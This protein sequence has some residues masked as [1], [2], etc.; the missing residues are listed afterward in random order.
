MT[1]AAATKMT[2]MGSTTTRVFNPATRLVAGRLPGFGI[3]THR[4]RRTGKLYHTPLLA[5][6]SGDDYVIGLWYGS[7]VHW[8]KNVIAAGTCQLEVRRRTVQVVDPVVFR[9]PNRSS[10]PLPLRLVGRVVG[11][12][13]FMRM[14]AV[15]G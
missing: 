10:M 14:P 13:E 11:L 5:F 6:R 7:E 9:D 3:V 15:A 1:V 4:G 8:V 12:T 2:F